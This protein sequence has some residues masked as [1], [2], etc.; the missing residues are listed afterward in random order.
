MPI[1]AYV[2]DGVVLE[3]CRVNPFDVF[4]PGYAAQFI[5]APDDCVAGWTYVGGVFAP[6]A[7]PVVTQAQLVAATQSLIDQTAQ[8]KGYNDGVSC[9]SYVNSTNATWSAQATAFVHWRDSVWTAAYM[10][11]G[12]VASG[13]QPM[14]TSIDAYL[15][16]LPVMVWP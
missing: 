10:L 11:Q 7:P 1:T 12:A 4:V 3:R 9:A 6:P 13:T 5:P 2:K 14:P 8:S 15:A 16:T